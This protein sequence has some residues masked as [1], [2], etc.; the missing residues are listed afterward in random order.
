MHSFAITPYIYSILSYISE[1]IY[2]L[3]INRK[4]K[5]KQATQ[6]EKEQDALMAFLS[7]MHKTSFLITSWKIITI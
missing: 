3:I 2:N 7:H 5:K 4:L 1:N 6:I